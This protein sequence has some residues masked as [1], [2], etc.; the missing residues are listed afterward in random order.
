MDWQSWPTG[1]PGPFVP[2][3]AMRETMRTFHFFDL[4]RNEWSRAEEKVF[5]IAEFSSTGQ[6]EFEG[7]SCLPVWITIRRV[8]KYFLDMSQNQSWLIY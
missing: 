7:Q 6:S 5:H 2:D 3:T 8:Q 4:K 1:R